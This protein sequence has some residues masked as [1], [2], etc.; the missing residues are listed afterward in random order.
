MSAGEKGTRQRGGPAGASREQSALGVALDFLRLLWA[1]D[2][3]LQRR[4]KR[5]EVELGVTGMQRI[6]IR[7]IGRYPEIAAGR[8]AELVHVHPSTLTGVLRRLVDRGFVQRDRD[9]EDAR[10]SKFLLLPPGETIDAT[11]AGTVEAAVRR[12]LARMPPETIDAARTVLAALAEEL[13]RSDR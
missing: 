2:H 13:G 3:G 1:V 10:R 6:V 12:A 7:L 5:M 11:Q 4:S 8:L 9:A